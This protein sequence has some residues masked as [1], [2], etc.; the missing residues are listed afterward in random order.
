MAL[1]ANAGLGYVLMTPLRHG[2]LALA[3]SLAAG[4]NFALLLV[5][6][7]KKLGRIGA[8]NIIRSFLK[9]LGASL[10][11]GA[12][13]LV[14]CSKGPWQTTGVTAEKIWLLLGAILVGIFVYGGS[15]YLFGS[16]ELHS[17]VEIIRKKMG[18]RN[19]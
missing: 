19:L 16:Q 17:A 8:S 12:V 4:L 3:T 6:L 10:L 7:R 14:I 5:L 15:C 2:G 9:S 11:M 18:Q 1:L 13:A